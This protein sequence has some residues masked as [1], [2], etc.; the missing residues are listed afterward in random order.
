LKFAQSDDNAR[1]IDVPGS[2]VEMIEAQVKARASLDRFWAVQASPRSGEEGF[3]LKVAVPVQG[4]ETEH[5]WT[6]NITREGQKVLG[7]VNNTPRRARTLRLGDR[8]EIVP[9]RI[10]DWMYLRNG[11]IVG[12]F[13][14]RPLL[15]RM[16][17]A[18]AER[19]RAMLAEP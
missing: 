19:Y 10:S 13:T 1:A 12:N 6:N 18:E 4:S 17:P 15:K 3:A 11:R 2:D 9:D 14:L 16:P 8:I 5:I 7:T